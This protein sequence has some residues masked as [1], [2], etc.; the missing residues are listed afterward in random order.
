MVHC[1]FVG[2]YCVL[3]AAISFPTD[4]TIGDICPAGHYCPQ[5]SS[6]YTAC[7]QGKFLPTEGNSV[8]S[9]CIT[10]TEGEYVNN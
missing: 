2:Y 7:A 3:G 4:G 8:E 9:S 1:Y 6:S 5:G 10:C